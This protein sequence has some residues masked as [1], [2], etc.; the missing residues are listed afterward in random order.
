M[1]GPVTY[2]TSAGGLGRSDEGRRAS[3]RGRVDPYPLTVRPLEVV[4]SAAPVVDLRTAPHAGPLDDGTGDGRGARAWEHAVDYL[5]RFVTGGSDGPVVGQVIKPFAR[6]RGA[7]H[8][9]LAEVLAALDD[10]RPVAFYGWWP[11]EGAADTT[12]ILGVDAME[13]PPPDRKRAGLVDGHTVVIVGYGCHDAF[14]G[15]GYVIVRN[16]WSGWGDAG[17]GYMPFTYLRTYATELWTARLAGGSTRGAA[18]GGPAAERQAGGG[19]RLPAVAP[20]DAADVA[21]DDRARCR[22][23]RASLLRLFFSEDLMELARARAICSTCPVRVPCLARALVRHEPCGV[24][25]GEILVDGR[26]VAEKRGRGRPPKVPRARL[27]VDE[28]TGVPIVA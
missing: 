6:R 1:I 20:R 19:A 9:Q 4:P 5:S 27:V 24:W 11:T 26:V 7:D 17:D 8:D 28:I 2:T 3:R 22:D 18:G 10:G 25:G 16:G 14:P 15:G 21:I 23:Q 13:V 12:E